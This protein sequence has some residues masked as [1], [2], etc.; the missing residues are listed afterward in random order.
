[1][2]D[3]PAAS[4]DPTDLRPAAARVRLRDFSRSLPMA[5]LRTREAVMRHFRPS[6]RHFD[7][8]EQQWRVLRALASVEEIEVT[9]LAEATFLLAPSL[10]RIL[11]DLDDRGVIRRRVSDADQRFG[12]VS[13]TESGH[14][15]IDRVGVHSESIY[16]ELTRRVG[17][18]RMAELLSLLREVETI[19]GE[20]AAIEVEVVD[21]GGMP[22]PPAAP[23]RR[24]G[25]P[26]KEG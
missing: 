1:M 11:R 23:V 7:L 26:R 6:L 10:S 9:R 21:P 4:P 16:G 25:R 18:A 14:D 15:L 3:G 5:L 8:T 20:G 17:E 24:R 12:L 13:L 19:V 2:D 22:P